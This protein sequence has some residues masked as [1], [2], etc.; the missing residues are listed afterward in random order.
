MSLEFQSGVD[1]A[2]PFNSTSASYEERASKRLKTSSFLKTGTEGVHS[3]QSIYQNPSFLTETDKQLLFNRKCNVPQPSSK[4][5]LNDHSASSQSCSNQEAFMSTMNQNEHH[6]LHINSL[7]RN[8]DVDPCA[9]DFVYVLPTQLERIKYMKAKQINLP[10]NLFNI[11]DENNILYFSQSSTDVDYVNFYKIIVPVGLYDSDELMTVI[12][13][14]FIYATPITG[15]YNLP[16]HDNSADTPNGTLTLL[17]DPVSKEMRLVTSVDNVTTSI[18]CPPLLSDDYNS[19]TFKIADA[20]ALVNDTF[21]SPASAT[22]T[23][24]RITITTEEELNIGDNSLFDITLVGETGKTITYSKMTNIYNPGWSSIISSANVKQRTFTFMVNSN[25]TVNRWPFA[26]RFPAVYFQSGTITVYTMKSNIAPVLGLKRSSSTRNWNKILNVIDDGTD[27]GIVTELPHGQFD[28]H[29][30]TNNY[31]LINNVLTGPFAHKALTDSAK[32]VITLASVSNLIPISQ[33]IA[34]GYQSST[35]ILTFDG[36]IN[37]NLD[38]SLF[39]SITMDDDRDVGTITMQNT[40][41]V[42]FA[43]ARYIRQATSSSKQYELDRII[44]DVNFKMVYPRLKKLR[45]RLYDQKHKLVRFEHG[46]NWSFDLF[47]SGRNF[48][49]DF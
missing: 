5:V 34:T 32:H 39:I 35:N 22:F 38:T 3:I 26:P 45:I 23:I 36:V 9:A 37:D 14:I 46:Q 13:R 31:L 28:T 19:L 16:G 7:Y 47:I 8:I 6:V 1:I 30:L 27:L 4:Y 25:D 40:D 12:N 15:T 49:Q 33:I 11:T 29:L 42:Y 20:G 2:T 24:D 21:T 18:H 41:R 10:N 43:K 17:A 48:S 44:G